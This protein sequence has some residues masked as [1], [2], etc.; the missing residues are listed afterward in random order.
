MTD[1]ERGLTPEGIRK[2]KRAGVGIVRLGS[3]KGGCAVF[4]SPLVRADQTAEILMRAL[5]EA[6]IK[7]HFKNSEQLAP[8]GNLERFIKEARAAGMETVFAVGHEPVLSDWAGRLCFGKAGRLKMKK[9]AVA[10][11]DLHDTGMGG[12]LVL[13]M[14][15]GALRQLVRK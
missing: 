4:S 11:I 9:G 14:Q 3:K 1:E 5:A 2:F 13:L 15:P 6:G 8:P 12:E 10:G 7:A